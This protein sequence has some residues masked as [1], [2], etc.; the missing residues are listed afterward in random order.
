MSQN[1]ENAGSRKQSVNPSQAGSRKASV[2]APKSAKPVEEP[3]KT[4]EPEEIK[5]K[6]VRTR[7]YN[8]LLYRVI[9]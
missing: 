4:E 5:E 3:P 7:N 9:F 6:P 8:I 2:A 1:N